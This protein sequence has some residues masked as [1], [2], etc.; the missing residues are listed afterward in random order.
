M[1]TA[2]GYILP[3]YLGGDALIARLFRTGVV[4]LTLAALTWRRIPDLPSLVRRSG[5]LVV[6]FVLLQNVFSPQWVLW[7]WPFLLPLVGRIPRLA[8]LIV[9]LDLATIA[10]WPFLPESWPVVPHALQFLRLAL[11]LAIVAVLLIRPAPKAV[12]A[13]TT[14]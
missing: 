7:F 9:A 11:M 1:W 10:I 5:I 8:F 3:T 14:A 13:V 4:L 12:G 2:Y 6:V